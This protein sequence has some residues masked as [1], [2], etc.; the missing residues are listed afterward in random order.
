MIAQSHSSGLEFRLKYGFLAAHRG[1]MAHIPQSQA[2]AGEITWYTQGYGRKAWQLPYRNPFMGFTTFFGSVGNDRILGKYFGAY[3]FIEFPF[4]KSDRFIFAGKL[5]AGLGYTKKIYDPISN[6]KNT[7]I[8][9]H[10]N[11]MICIAL[12]SQY[13]LNERNYLSFAIDMTHF[14]NGAS[15]TPNLGLNL[16]YLSLGYGYSFQH[17][18]WKAEEIVAPSSVIPQRRWVYGGMLIGSFKEIYPT[19]GKKYPVFA[20]NLHAKRYFR[21]KVAMELGVD[22]ISKQAIMDYK[23]EIPKSQWDIL[24]M[25][26]F[27]GYILPLDRLQF[28]LGMGAYF[29]DKIQPESIFY[30]RVG[31]R[32]YF[33]QGWHANLVLKSNF[34]KADYVEYG[35]GYTFKYKP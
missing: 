27:A 20:L 19:G 18:K 7:A 34:A 12:K 25:G 28:I 23:R 16:P 11:A 14:S 1:V 10:F 17:Q 21:P 5:G 2:Y 29:K 22:F 9:S 24:Q 30:H 26:V 3:G 35:I 33:H 32:Y 31:M 15:Q 8:G 13:F 6:P 4:V